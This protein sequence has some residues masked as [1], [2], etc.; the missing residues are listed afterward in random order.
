MVLQSLEEKR[1]S[2][3]EKHP[4][5]LPSS[6]IRSLKHW[7]FKTTQ[8]V[9]PPKCPRKSMNRRRWKLAGGPLRSFEH[10]SFPR[11][12]VTDSAQGFPVSE[13]YRGSHSSRES[14][15]Q[16]KAEPSDRWYNS[17]F[18]ILNRVTF[19][20]AMLCNLQPSVS[21]QDVTCF[22]SLVLCI[23][24]PSFFAILLRNFYPLFFVLS[25]VPVA[26]MCTTADVRVTLLVYFSKRNKSDFLIYFIF[27]K[28][29]TKYTYP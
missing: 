18:N 3:S 11:Q 22:P 6:R 12:D 24:W 4:I 20:A 5:S 8:K 15:S 19:S 14:H 29:I 26:R 21:A 10:I 25:V 9:S 13:D 27:W 2:I 17:L 28:F 16:T 23:L 1:P 7:T